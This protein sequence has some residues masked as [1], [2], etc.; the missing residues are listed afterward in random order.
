MAR[1]EDGGGEGDEAQTGEGNQRDRD[2]DDYPR[3]PGQPELLLTLGRLD[4]EVAAA[5]E[6]IA[7][8]VGD[9]GVR[10]QL[11]EMRDDHRR[12]AEELQGLLVARGV[13]AS[14]LAGLQQ[15]QEYSL[16]RPLADLV[17]P[18]GSGFAIVTLIANEHLTNA[19]YEGALE[20]D[21]SDEEIEFLDRAFLDE[22]DHLEWLLA[23]ETVMM[24]EGDEAAAAARPD[25]PA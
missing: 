3:P 22:Q 12:H 16:L 10:S 8:E 14:V 21:W 7:S 1:P 24:G 11:L 9:D 4:L 20:Y 5:Y 2:D 17:R 23:Q 6:V 15:A 19:A 13:D 18:L 25:V